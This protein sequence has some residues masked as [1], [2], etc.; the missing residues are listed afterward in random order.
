MG[1]R[2]HWYNDLDETSHTSESQ[3]MSSS[4]IVS[5]T[6]Q[7]EKLWETQYQ[8]ESGCTG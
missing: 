5:I 2:S 6:N 7:I 8:I 3:V 4:R 1:I